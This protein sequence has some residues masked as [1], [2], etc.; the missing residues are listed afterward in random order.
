MLPVISC[1]RMTDPVV[2]GSSTAVD[3]R[4]VAERNHLPQFCFRNSRGRSKSYRATEAKPRL[5]IYN[6]HVVIRDYIAISCA[7]QHCF[8]Q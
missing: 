2:F 4:F 3:G 5:L 7:E 6:S 8:H 1:V